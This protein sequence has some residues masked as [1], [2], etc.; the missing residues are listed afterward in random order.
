MASM[1]YNLV[2]SDA[3]GLNQVNQQRS[4]QLNNRIGGKIF[5]LYPFNNKYRKIQS[6]CPP[7]FEDGRKTIGDGTMPDPQFYIYMYCV[8]FFRCLKFWEWALSAEWPD[9][10]YSMVINI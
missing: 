6:K 2:I 10:R 9:A 7:K 3:Q 5:V 4:Q 1:H 8:Y